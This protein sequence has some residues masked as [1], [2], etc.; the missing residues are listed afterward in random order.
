MSTSTKRYGA[1]EIAA[2]KAGTGDRNGT[3]SALVSVFGNVDHGGDRV[4]PGAFTKS[5]A[6]WEASGDPIPVIWNHA[7]DNP[8]AHIGKVNPSDAVE[9]AEGLVVMGSRP[10]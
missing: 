7:W 10:R 4:M 9:T 3:F 6:R 8:A 5:L 2:F 1:F